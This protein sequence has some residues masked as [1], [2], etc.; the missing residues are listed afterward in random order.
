MQG[1]LI[2][3]LAIIKMQLILVPPLVP[4]HFVSE[5]CR[6]IASTAAS[7]LV[8]TASLLFLSPLSLSLFLA[9][10]KYAPREMKRCQG[11]FLASVKIAGSVDYFH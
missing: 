3:E 11:D 9:L 8:I 5:I 1:S 4:S 10:S 6:A 2:K 7:S